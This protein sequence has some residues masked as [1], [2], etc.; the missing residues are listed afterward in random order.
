M[1]RM[2]EDT[3]LA[4]LQ[5]LEDDAAAFVSSTLGGER[6]LALREY[7]RQPYG[8]ETDGWSSIVTSAVLDTVEWM[9]PDLLD[10]FTS[11][12]EAVQFTPQQAKDEDGAQQATDACNYIFYRQSP[13]NGFVT[14][15]T[16]FKDALLEKICAVMW[17]K[18]S[19]RT[20]TIIP[21]R[22]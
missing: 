3:L 12:D 9:L 22:M 17:R 14:L 16:A 19:E 8:T 20:K 10:I 2:D 13:N 18:M 6:E 5:R 15:Y 11:S 4:M 21:V 7:F 1:A